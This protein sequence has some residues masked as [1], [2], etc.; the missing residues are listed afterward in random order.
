[1]SPH[2]LPS[3]LPRLLRSGTAPGAATAFGVAL[4]ALFLLAGSA[5]ATV[6]DDLCTGDPCVITGSHP[7]TD[8]SVL[9]FGT[10]AVILEG[11][12]D[13]GSGTATVQAGSFTIAPSGL[14]KGR[15]GTVDL[16]GTFTVVTPGDIVIDGTSLLGAIQLT[17]SDGGSLTLTSTAGEVRGAGGINASGSGTFDFGGDIAISGAAGVDLTG[18]VRA[19]GGTNGGGGII[20]IDSASGP[21]TLTGVDVSGG[22]AGDITVTAGTDA[23][24]GGLKARGTGDA[25][26]GGVI[27]VTATG[28]VD[29]TGPLDTLGA[30][31]DGDG[32]SV[33]LISGTPGARSHV[34]VD[35]DLIAS[36]R[37]DGFGGEIDVD[38]DTVTLAAL[39]EARGKGTFGA[40]GTVTIRGEDAIVHAGDL[41]AAGGDLGGDVLLEAGNGVQVDGPIDASASASS[42]GGGIIVRSQGSV[43]VH[44]SVTAN[45]GSDA[46]GGDV[47]LEGCFV[48]VGPSV[49]VEALGDVGSI[50]VVV[51]DT[52]VL[53][54]AFQ[55]G[56]PIGLI[57]V[58]YP[59]PANRPDMTAGTFSPPVTE[60]VDPLVP[61]CAGDSDGDGLADDVDNCPSIPNPGQEDAD[62]DGVGDACDNCVVDPNP[63]QADLD[64]PADDDGSLAGIQHYGDV[65]DADLDDDG[66]VGNSDFFGRFRPCLGAD[67]ALDPGCAEADLDGDGVVGTSDFFGVLRPALGTAPGPGWT[68]P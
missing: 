1:M 29:V 66:I 46:L 27:V 7:V 9:D 19:T 61:L 44:A 57:E 59:T 11:T 63:D 30:L 62:L 41:Q 28:R 43:E 33:Q 31:V 37:G 3:T 52:G 55:A 21:V 34:Q 39:L 54:G 6:A 13:L 2:A 25:G 24:V 40:G 60:V 14:V 42:S 45:G 26:G 67:P 48:D 49:P 17:G 20:D 56:G 68:E 53:S 18:L 58:R 12:L 35:G 47:L 8:L 50:R 23:T 22:D 16:G 5:A 38:G 15:G 4:A 51:R 64:F 36:G 10:R 65:C 32:G